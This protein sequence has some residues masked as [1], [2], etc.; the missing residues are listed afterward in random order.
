MSAMSLQNSSVIKTS[1]L[2]IIHDHLRWQE[3]RVLTFHK[4]LAFEKITNHLI[5]RRAHIQFP[6]AIVR[7]ELEL[8]LSFW[9]GSLNLW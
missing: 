5:L 9:Y 6:L 4:F 3:A 1:P 2:A 7:F 8:V